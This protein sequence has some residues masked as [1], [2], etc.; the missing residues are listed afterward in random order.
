VSKNGNGKGSIYPHKCN[1]KKVGYRGSY[2]VYTA[3]GP[4]RRYVSGKD[5][6]DV[7]QKLTKAIAD[8]DGGLVFEDENLTVAEYM[9]RWLDNSVRGSVRECTYDSYRRLARGYIVPVIGR[10]KLKKLTPMRVQAMYRDM[11][12]RGLSPRTVQYT[13]AVLELAA[14]GHGL[15][16]GRASQR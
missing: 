3:A 11:Q 2:T 5:R 10:V 1:G 4:K 7:R 6:D 9:E 8:R 13:H 15:R 14:I 12:D 16:G